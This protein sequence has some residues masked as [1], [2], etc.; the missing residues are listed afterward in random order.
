[1]RR[2]RAVIVLALLGACA[3]RPSA[4]LPDGAVARGTTDVASCGD[5]TGTY[6][7]QRHAIF[8]F[9]LRP[10]LSATLV[11][12]PFDSVHVD[13]VAAD[14]LAFALAHGTAVDTVWLVAGR[15]YDCA[16]GWIR[17]LV[18]LTVDQLPSELIDP[19]R[20]D[21]RADDFQFEMIG[22]VRGRLLARVVHESYR[23][24]SVWA[25]SPGGRIPGTSRWSVS[26]YEWGPPGAWSPEALRDSEQTQRIMNE[27]YRLEYGKD[28]PR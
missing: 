21:D 20:N 25:D 10:R 9:L 15:H 22:V 13:G 2:R 7:V 17:T 1:V 26:W 23:T 11:A 18:E 4:S 19:V 27:E 14:S 8:D 6:G 12:E 3:G 16:N 5:V 24:I 28:P